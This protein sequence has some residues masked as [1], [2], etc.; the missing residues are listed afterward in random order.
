MKDK[1]FHFKQFSVHHHRSSMKIGTDAL[2]LGAWCKVEGKTNI[3]E[4][5]CG[6][7]VISLMLAQRNSQAQILAI[8]LDL[9]SVEESNE[10]FD[11]S[12]WAERLNA[13]QHN[14]MEAELT[15]TI[16]LIVS[17]PPFFSNALE[18]PKNSRNNAR[19]SVTFDRALFFRKCKEITFDNGKIAIIVPFEDAIV[20]TK[21]ASEF[22]LHTNRIMEVKDTKDRDSKRI[23]IE[24]GKEQV[25]LESETLILKENKTFSRDYVQL[26]NEFQIIF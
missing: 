24:F 17:N 16:D 22:H 14:F 21:I 10:N 9:P 6:C 18:S 5:G 8:D 13:Q 1:P 26:L 23:M 3:L 15:E 19:H 12:P 20:W 11:A 7:G 25:Q 4:V 2:L